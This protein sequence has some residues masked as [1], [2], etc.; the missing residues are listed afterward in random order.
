VQIPYDTKGQEKEKIDI[1]RAITAERVR[2][3]VKGYTYIR[4]MSRGK[5]SGVTVPGLGGSFA[6]VHVGDR[7][8]GE[9]RDLGERLPSFEE[10]AKYIF[11]TETSRQCDLKKMDPA[12]GFIGA[13]EAAGGTS[14]YLL[15]TPKRK[16][17]REMSLVTLKALA[18]KDKNRNWVIYCEKIWLHQDQLRKFEQEHGKRIRPMLV[19]FNLK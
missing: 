17:D 16:E 14:Y 5:T 3:V 6:Y 15:Y 4:R 8:F 11:Y 7:L 9:Y 12:S 2:R 18:E 19:P 13:T 1:C 10:L